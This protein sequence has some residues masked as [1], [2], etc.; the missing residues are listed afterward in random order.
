MMKVYIITCHNV[1]NAGASLQA[2]ALVTYLNNLGYEAKIIDYTPNYLSRYRLLGI[3]SKRY[4]KPVLRELYQIVKLPGRLKKRLSPKKRA[5]DHFTRKLPLTGNYHS[6]SELLSDPPLADV[7]LAGSDQIWN[8]LFSNG[9]DP[10]FYLDFVPAGRIRAS[11]AASFAAEDITEEWKP[12][13][14]KWLQHFDDISVRESSGLRIIN[15]L[16]IPGAVQVCDPVF[17]LS[18][19][20]W[21]ELEE[22]LQLEEPYLLVYDFDSNPQIREFCTE[23]SCK[24]GW[25]IYSILKNDYCDRCFHQKGP[26]AFLTLLRHAEFVVSNSFHAMAFSLMFQ[27]QFVVFRRNERINTRMEDLLELLS[28]KHVL[29]PEC[30]PPKPIDYDAVNPALIR[31]VDFSKTYI[32][33]VMEK[34]VQHNLSKEHI[35]DRE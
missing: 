5:Y 15:N 17:L 28:L 24:Y 23:A 16:G 22:P 21:E 9:K 4:D 10:A 20:Q 26:T 34:A 14:R 3:N 6:Y 32:S 2:Y 29:D 7:Y 8:T 13:I 25:K 27:K 1:Y 18:C 33:S 19:T 35:N 11:Y 30:F 12:Q 31:F